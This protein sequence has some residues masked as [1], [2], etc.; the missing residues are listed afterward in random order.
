MPGGGTFRQAGALL[1]TFDHTFATIVQLTPELVAR[2]H[3]LGAL[4]LP[5]GSGLHHA[6][7]GTLELLAVSI[8][9]RPPFNGP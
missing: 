8:L 3:K 4:A 7:E 2:R 5:R 1:R 9:R 6:I